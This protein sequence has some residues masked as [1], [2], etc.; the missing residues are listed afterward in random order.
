MAK[1]NS[2]S[3]AN[4]VWQ[5]LLFANSQNDMGREQIGHLQVFGNFDLAK[6][7]FYWF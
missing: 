2:N 5:M 6:T 1:S 3:F 7:K 4:F